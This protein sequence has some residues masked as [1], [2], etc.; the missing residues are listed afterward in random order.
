MTTSFPPLRLLGAVLLLTLVFASPA[1]AAGGSAAVFGSYWERF[2]EHWHGVFKRQNGV[3]M[4][5]LGVGVVA[6]FIITR[7][8]WRK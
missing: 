2:L 5:V 8:K 1:A 7:G 3:I 6:L 4:G